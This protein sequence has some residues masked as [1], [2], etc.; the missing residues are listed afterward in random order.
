MNKLWKHLNL[1]TLITKGDERKFISKL[2]SKYL[3]F[4]FFNSTFLSSK[5]SILLKICIFLK[6]FF[7]FILSDQENRKFCK[8]IIKNFVPEILAGKR[9]QKLGKVK[10]DG[11]S[12]IFRNIMPLRWPG[13]AV[14]IIRFNCVVKRDL[15]WSN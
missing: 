1:A 7:S 6:L 12:L 11:S 4:S 5:D 13:N 10:I 8:L 9:I 2:H 15:V 3:P 14:R